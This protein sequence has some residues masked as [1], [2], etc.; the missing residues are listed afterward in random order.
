MSKYPYL[1]LNNSVETRFNLTD[2]FSTQQKT[3]AKL[4]EVKREIE[5]TINDK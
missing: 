1:L 3:P 4:T 2:H 5:M